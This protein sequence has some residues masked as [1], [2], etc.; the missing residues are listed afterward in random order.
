MD[1]V[2]I[3]IPIPKRKIDKPFFTTV[4]NVFP[5]K[6]HGTIVTR[7]IERRIIRVG[8]IV[9]ITGLRGSHITVVTS[10]AMFQKLLRKVLLEIMW[11][12]YSRMCKE[13]TYNV[14]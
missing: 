11:E 9:E 5:T 1:Q 3:H 10:L 7:H 4:E 14:E 12:Y 6:D 2:N 8:E 13:K